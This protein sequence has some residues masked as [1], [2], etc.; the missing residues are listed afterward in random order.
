MLRKGGSNPDDRENPSV[1]LIEKQIKHGAD[2]MPIET[3]I[4]NEAEYDIFA[5]EK[6][7]FQGVDT[8]SDRQLKKLRSAVPV[9]EIPA[10]HSPGEI[11]IKRVKEFTR[12][13]APVAKREKQ[14]NKSGTTHKDTVKK[15]KI[16][17][18]SKN[19]ALER[20]VSQLNENII[21]M[22][23]ADLM[24]ISPACRVRWSKE[25]RIRRGPDMSSESLM[26]TA[27]EA[28]IN[29]LLYI[30]DSKFGEQFR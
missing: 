10:R 19:A 25:L 2:A 29:Q 17:N 24:D 12:P 6:R 1:L 22:K 23:V 26:D 30:D 20:V 5:Q 14:I 9:V 7:K 8:P 18:E 3:N 15:A 4:V 21:P 28:N 13:R 11:T 27:D 16:P